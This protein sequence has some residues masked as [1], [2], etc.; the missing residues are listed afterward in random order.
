M[1]DDLLS[2][3]LPQFVTL[4]RT[5]IETAITAA[6]KRDADSVKTTVRELH[7]L[8]GE[9]GLLGLAQVVPLAREC[10]Q[11]AKHLHASQTD[12]EVVGLVDA[13]RELNRMIEVIGGTAPQ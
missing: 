1:M 7:T 5:R 6:K 11:K 4:A 3:F 10:E 13:L 12:A 9:A 2:R 8:V